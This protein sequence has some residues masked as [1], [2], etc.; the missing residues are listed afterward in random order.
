MHIGQ[1]AHAVWWMAM[2]L[3][4]AAL[5]RTDVPMQV[6]RPLVLYLGHGSTEADI[7]YQRFAVALARARRE[8]FGELRLGYASIPD[9]LDDSLPALARAMML[10]PALIVAPTAGSMRAASRLAGDTPVVLSSYMDPIRSGFVDSLRARSKPV[11]GVDLTDQLDGKRLEILHEAYPNVRSIAVIADPEWASDTAAVQRVESESRALGIR[12]TVLFADSRA[13]LQ[14]LFA[15]PATRQYDGWYVPPTYLEERARD[16]IAQ[17]MRSWGKPCI[18][19]ETFDVRSGGLMSYTQDASF[20]WDALAE[21]VGRVLDGEPPGA[22]PIVRPQRFELA[23][24]VSP[25]IGVPPPVDGVLA[26]ADIIVR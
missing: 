26:R 1:M 4:A 22:I 9:H 10:H 23:V 3:A 7:G 16:L 11:T 8:R 20:A 14:A 5:L 25:D 13:E 15:R 12:V 19:S 18:Y 21:L 6:A 24:R 2:T 17:T